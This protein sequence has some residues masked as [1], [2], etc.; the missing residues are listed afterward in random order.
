MAKKVT[1]EFVIEQIRKVTEDFEKFGK[2]VPSLAQKGL[3]FLNFDE[4]QGRR[5]MSVEIGSIFIKKGLNLDTVAHLVNSKF[6]AKT[7]LVIIKAIVK[8]FADFDITEPNREGSAAQVIQIIAATKLN[9]IYGLTAGE[10]LGMLKSITVDTKYGSP[11]EN[12]LKY[13]A[14]NKLPVNKNSRDVLL[15]RAQVQVEN[16][17]YNTEMIP[18]LSCAMSNIITYMLAEASMN[19][20]DDV[21]RVV[22][23]T[24]TPT[25]EA[26]DKKREIVADVFQHINISKYATAIQEYNSEFYPEGKKR[27]RKPKV[28]EN[29]TI[30]AAK[31][32]T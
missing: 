26:A 27:T 10:T 25:K 23:S 11:V 13:I 24:M 9:Q 15:L 18:I 2:Q 32:K 3:A 20:I 16:I 29:T 7:S 6:S 17:F 14:E 4:K 31:T 8:A 1:E 21:I 22:S 5:V 28:A 12:V 30:E 19:R